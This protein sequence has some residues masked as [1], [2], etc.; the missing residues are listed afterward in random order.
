[1][2]RTPLPKR[3]TPIRRAPVRKVNPKRKASEWARCYGSKARVRFVAWL[4][5]ACGCGLRPC[6]NAH[7][8]T[9][10]M[11]RKGDYDTVVP[12]TPECHRRVHQSGWHGDLARSEEF[13]RGYAVGIEM[14][15]QAHLNRGTEP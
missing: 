4:P 14:M 7:I 5:C 6:E 9:G 15:W 12:L 3:R 2:K 8:G 13:R 1:M 10:G 11:G